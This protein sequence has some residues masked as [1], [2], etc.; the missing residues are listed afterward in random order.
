[1]HM[2][3]SK[4]YKYLSQ[5]WNNCSIFNDCQAFRDKVIEFSQPEGVNLANSVRIDNLYLEL[6]KKR[7]DEGEV[8]KLAGELTAEDKTAIQSGGMKDKWLS[9]IYDKLGGEEHAKM[10]KELLAMLGL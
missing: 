4:N 7:P 6:S 10:R 1:M 9:L 2:Y 5:A 8:R 3:V